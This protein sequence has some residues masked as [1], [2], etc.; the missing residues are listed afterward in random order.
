MRIL[1]LDF[2]ERRIG[3]ALSDASAITAQPL[4]V[5]ERHGLAKDIQSIEAL[6]RQHA[7]ESIVMGLPLTLEGERGPQAQRALAFGSELKRATQIPL[8]WVDERFTTAQGIKALSE[9]GESGRQQRKRID[10][11]AAQL[12]LQSYL[13]SKNA[14]KT[15]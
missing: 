15:G 3:V 11:V 1:G 6:I 8:E 10:Q 7:V 2:G 9:A 14:Q 4:T 5:I 12:I 13:D